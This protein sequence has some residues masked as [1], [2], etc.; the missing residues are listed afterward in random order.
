MRDQD[1]I[2]SICMFLLLL[3]SSFL[4]FLRIDSFGRKEFCYHPSFDLSRLQVEI[5]HHLLILAVRSLLAFLFFST[6]LVPPPPPPFNPASLRRF[7]FFLHIHTYIYLFVFRLNSRLLK[8][9]G[10]SGCLMR[11][12]NVLFPLDR[13]SLASPYSVSLIWSKRVEISSIL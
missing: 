2:E 11:D 3:L 13:I 8:L 10:D 6:A 12:V 7:L 5:Q 4:Q 9:D 1:Y